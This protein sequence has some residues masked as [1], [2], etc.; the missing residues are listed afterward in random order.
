[1]KIEAEGL[2]QQECDDQSSDK[3]RVDFADTNCEI[4]TNDKQ[5]GRIECKLDHPPVAGRHHG[6]VSGICG[7]FDYK[8]TSPID[9]PLIVESVTPSENLSSLGGDLLIIKGSGFSALQA[10]EVALDD[11]TVCRVRSF[12]S[13]EIKCITGRLDQSGEKSTYG[14]AVNVN[15][16]QQSS[17]VNLS[18]GAQLA[19]S[20]AP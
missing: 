7:N 13:T 1:L 19:D 5:A 14:L 10:P 2:V 17:D 15:G 9:V 6:K 18:V 3:I 16:I 4:S 11:G 12:T 8:S 20:I